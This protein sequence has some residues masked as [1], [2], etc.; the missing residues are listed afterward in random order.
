MPFIT[1]KRPRSKPLKLYQITLRD[2]VGRNMKDQYVEAGDAKEARDKVRE[3][4]FKKFPQMLFAM[5]ALSEV[6][7]VIR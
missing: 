5:G 1:S 2:S 4:L 6:G 7:I 3:Y